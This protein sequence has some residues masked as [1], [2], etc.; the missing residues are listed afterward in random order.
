MAGKIKNITHNARFNIGRLISIYKRAFD[1]WAIAGLAE[2]G[3]PLF[4]ISH[5]AVLMNINENGKTNKE[6]AAAAKVSKQAMSRFVN[7]LKGMKLIEVT[8]HPDD[9]R[10]A[11]LKLTAKGRAMVNETK[12]VMI[13]LESY[14]ENAIGKKAFLNYKE[15]T[16]K[17]INLH[18]PE[19]DP[20]H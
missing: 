5:F 13:Q 7:E 12:D 3:Y 20:Y 4:K 6:I 19:F 2:R 14:Y 16:A 11:L 17:L 9:N 18:W 8:K 1:E 15:T 10:S